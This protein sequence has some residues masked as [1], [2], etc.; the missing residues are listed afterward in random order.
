MDMIV[1][2]ALAFGVF[3]AMVAHALRPT[4]QRQALRIR[5]E[6]RQPRRRG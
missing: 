6:D 3:A 2:T 5:I 4:D 1:T